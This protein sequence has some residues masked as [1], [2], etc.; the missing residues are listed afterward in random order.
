MFGGTLEIWSL[1]KNRDYNTANKT[2][3]WIQIQ[4]W[5]LDRPE[6][7]KNLIFFC[8]KDDWKNNKIKIAEVTVT[9][10]ILTKN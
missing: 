4:K 9:N 1:V 3:L 7:L 6:I 10:F 8:S 5:N 2:S